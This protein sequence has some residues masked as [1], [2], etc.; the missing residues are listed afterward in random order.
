MRET[1]QKTKNSYGLVSWQIL[2]AFRLF[3]K[4]ISQPYC[5][6]RL[7][8]CQQCFFCLAAALWIL[9]GS[10]C[11]QARR[12]FSILGQLTRCIG[13]NLI[14]WSD[15]GTISPQMKVTSSLQKPP[16][17]KKTGQIEFTC[18]ELVT[19]SKSDLRM[20]V[21]C[22]RESYILVSMKLL[23]SATCTYCHCYVFV[24]GQTSRRLI[25]ALILPSHFDF[26][27][28]FGLN[29][30]L[31]VPENTR[32]TENHKSKLSPQNK[33]KWFVPTCLTLLSLWISAS[34]CFCGIIQP[35]THFTV[36]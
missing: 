32:A 18:Q 24:K 21:A 6:R 23:L 4:G 7:Q 2:W 15:V 17:E 13:L 28:T 11:S 20:I 14:F 30:I 16:G 31:H 8:R 29:Q 33:I 35:P 36:C 25:R 10:P 12:R 9:S 27:I 34:H 3:L 1:K 22:E 26:G 5:N 19:F